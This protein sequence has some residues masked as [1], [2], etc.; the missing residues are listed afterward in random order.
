M[1]I[2]SS[3][4]DSKSIKVLFLLVVM[5]F[6]LITIPESYAGYSHGPRQTGEAVL[7]E[8]L[9]GTKKFVVRVGSGGCTS[10]GSFKVEVK[11]EDGLSKISPHYVLTIMR[12][13][14]DECKALLADGILILFDMEKDVGIKGQ[15]TYSLTNQVYSSSRDQMWDEPILTVIEKHFNLTVPESGK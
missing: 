12:I 7:D 9:M 2:Y 3:I 11:K 10:K 15:F 4:S 13:S 6:V 1:K 8:I 14:V 5:A